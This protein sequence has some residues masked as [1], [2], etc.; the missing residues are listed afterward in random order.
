MRCLGDL[1]VSSWL[2]RRDT[3][4]RSIHELSAAANDASAP[5]VF[6]HLGVLNVPS[7]TPPRPKV[8]KHGWH[9]RLAALATKP[10]E[11][12]GLEIAQRVRVEPFKL[13]GQLVAR[14]E[15]G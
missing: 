12:F 15:V 8:R 11:Y 14:G 5:A 7:S 13:L 10:H 4:A 2:R 1:F 3:L 9:R 6:Y